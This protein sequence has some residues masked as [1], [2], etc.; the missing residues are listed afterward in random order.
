M[1]GRV[2][3]K[4]ISFRFRGTIFLPYLGH[5]G[6]FRIFYKFN[7][8]VVISNIQCTS[9]YQ[10][11]EILQVIASVSSNSSQVVNQTY[12][13]IPGVQS[14]QRNPCHSTVFFVLRRLALVPPRSSL[15][16]SL[17]S[18]QN[19][20]SSC[21][22]IRLV[23]YVKLH[24]CQTSRMLNVRASQWENACVTSRFKIELFLCGK[25]VL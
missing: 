13:Q 24:I 17:A 20:K 3:K 15:L 21:L 7:C 16:F 18:T 22:S 12:T 6:C 2:L 1:F 8:I 14:V 19:V 25:H 4:R 23:R 10:Q 11:V 9:M 5:F